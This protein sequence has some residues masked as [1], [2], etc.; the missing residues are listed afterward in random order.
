MSILLQYS[1]SP[2]GICLV[3]VFSSGGAENVG[4]EECGIVYVYYRCEGFPLPMITILPCFSN[5]YLLFR[6]MER[7]DLTEVSEQEEGVHCFKEE[8][9]L[10]ICRSTGYSKREKLELAKE[11]FEVTVSV[12]RAAVAREN[13]D[14]EME[15]DNKVDAIRK[16]D[17]ATSSNAAEKNNCHS[18]RSPDSNIVIQDNALPVRFENDDTNNKEKGTFQIN[19]LPQVAFLKILSYL[20]MKERVTASV[21]SK[22]W[23]NSCFDPCLW[24]NIRLRERKSVTDDVFYRLTDLSSSLNVLDIFECGNITER[25]LAEGLCQCSQLIELRAVRCPNFTDFCMEKVGET[26]KQLKL[27]DISLC[28][29]V[30]DDGI[31]KV[32]YDIV[33][34]KLIHVMVIKCSDSWRGGGGVV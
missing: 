4:A 34:I 13:D 10:H 19:S 15:C 1:P 28:T 27:L 26:C 32:S 22:Y 5:Q 30:T 16:K 8:Q 9:P 14:T 7:S 17:V 20:T 23:Y 25:G 18:F 24:R 33:L 11:D 3:R 31:Q 6:L 21:V 2:H 12:K 29:K